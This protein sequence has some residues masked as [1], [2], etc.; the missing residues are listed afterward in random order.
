M[1]ARTRLI[2]TLLACGHTGRQV[3]AQVGSSRE[4][5]KVIAFHHKAELNAI[6]ASLLPAIVAAAQQAIVATTINRLNTNPH[7]SAQKRGKTA[8][9]SP[10]RRLF[11]M[12]RRKPPWMRDDP[13]PARTGD[14][15]ADSLTSS[16][17]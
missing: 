15:E 14:P 9:N 3:A 1:T 13:T 12:G 11:R 16:G 6:Q 2:L 8:K 17:L 7:K 10:K 5:I 4:S